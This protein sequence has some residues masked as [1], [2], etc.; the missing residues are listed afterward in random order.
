MAMKKNPRKM[1]VPCGRRIAA[2]RIAV[3]T[4][5]HVQN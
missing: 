3:A 1:R 4:T 5:N 2:T